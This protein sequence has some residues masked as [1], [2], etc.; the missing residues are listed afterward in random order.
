[1]KIL[2]LGMLVSVSLL[3][4]GCLYGQCMDGPCAFERERILKSI[5]TYGAY[6]VKPGMTIEKRSQDSIDCGG[7]TRGPDF[8][9][10]QLDAA[11]QVE[12]KNDFAPGTRLSKAWVQCMKEKGYHYEE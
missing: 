8:S 5:K 2:H 3:L 11:R 4:S 6:W 1:M 7:S 12:D 9:K 10:Q